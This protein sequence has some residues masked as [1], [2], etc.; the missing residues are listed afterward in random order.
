MFSWRGNLLVV[1]E[2]VVLPL[3]SWPSLQEL[4]LWLDDVSFSCL[5]G[6]YEVHFC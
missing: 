2:M 1:I 4:Q 6:K 3:L 5:V